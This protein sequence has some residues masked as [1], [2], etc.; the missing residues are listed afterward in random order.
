MSVINDE[1]RCASGNRFPSTIC[2]S[3]FAFFLLIHFTHFFKTFFQT[4][5]LCCIVPKQ[6][7]YSYKISY[8]TD[9]QGQK[10]I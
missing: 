2:S 9:K 6:K 1:W 10:K 5:F 3:S 7:S 4:H 8:K